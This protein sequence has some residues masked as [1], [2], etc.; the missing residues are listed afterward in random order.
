M[1]ELYYQ[2]WLVRRYRTSTGLK[3]EATNNPCRL[4]QRVVDAYVRGG[5]VAAVKMLQKEKPGLSLREIKA[6]IDVER[7]GGK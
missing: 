2:D 7:E 3:F 1:E 6:H 4:S 5:I